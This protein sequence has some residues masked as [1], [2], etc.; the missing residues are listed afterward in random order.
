MPVLYLAEEGSIMGIEGDTFRIIQKN[1]VIRS[2][3]ILSVD[4]VVVFGGTQISSKAI[5]LLLEKDIPT[6]FLSNSG[7]YYGRL[8]STETKSS[9]LRLEQIK[10]LE[11]KALMLSFAKEIIKGKILNCC[12]I[13]NNLNRARSFS[14]IKQKVN[15][16]Y[17]ILKNIP[18]AKT[19]DSL[20]GYEGS[21]ASIYY[22]TFPFVL[23]ETFG[24]KSRNKRPPKDPI[25]SLLS[26]GYTLLMYHVYTAI[27]V[28]GLD[29]SFG[30]FHTVEDNRP[31]LAL[32]LMEEFRP[33]IAD[34]VVFDMVNH[35]MVK[36]EH[37]H[38]SDDGKY[39]VLMNNDLRKKFIEKFEKRISTVVMYEGDRMSYR[40]V[41]EAQAR[42]LVRMIRNG[43]TYSAFIQK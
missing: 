43:N 28:V 14:E 24:F 21:A 38:T 9:K 30:Y 18:L 6:A 37:F 36:A 8:F 17:Q 39:P 4:G 42:K 35:G 16:L 2:V 32:D 33:L 1:G 11:D 31:S 3:P 20:R 26:F 12:Y 7:R 13:L 5:Q 41:I 22:S 29:P 10:S 40:R 15:S 25:N 23:N 34:Q 27:V 19:I